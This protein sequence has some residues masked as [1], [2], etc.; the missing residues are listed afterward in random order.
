MIFFCFLEFFAIDFWKIPTCTALLPPARLLIFEI[1]QPA[2]L[3]PPACLLDTL[4]YAYFPR[5][6]F[7]GLR[8][9]ETSEYS[10]FMTLV[11]TFLFRECMYSRR[12]YWEVIKVS[13][14]WPRWN[15]PWWSKWSKS[16]WS[17]FPF[18][19]WIHQKWIQSFSIL[20]PRHG[21]CTIQ[22]RLWICNI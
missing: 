1:F 15:C 8:H 14:S 5:Q 10:T 11:K 2:C 20:V 4:E 12:W 3:L 21:P 13:S 19:F 7:K 22:K 9:F 18:F 17:F 6:F 16:R